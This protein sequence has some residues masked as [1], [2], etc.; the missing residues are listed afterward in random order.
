MVE[1]VGR[2]MAM[3]VAFLVVSIGLLV[4]PD[5]PFRLGLDL[6]GGTRLVY[7]FDFEQARADG[8]L[9][10]E[11]TD[12]EVL[13][14]QIGIINNRVDPDGVLNPVI[15]SE[16]TNRIVIELP[17]KVNEERATAPL[18]AALTQT[19]S[20][21]LI[22]QG[23]SEA[24][25]FPLDG[26]V[27]LVGG[28][29]I[30]YAQRRGTELRGLTRGMGGGAQAGQHTQGTDVQLISGDP[31]RTRIENLGQLKFRILADANS[32]QRNVTDEVAER[33]KLDAW[34]TANPDATNL[35]GFN[36]LAGTAEGPIGVEWYPHKQVDGAAEM[37]LSERA[38][39][40]IVQSNEDWEFGGEDLGAVWLIP[41]DERTTFPACGFRMTS[42]ARNDF[43]DFT[44]ANS[45]KQLGIILNNEI[46]TAPGLDEPLTGDSRITGRFQLEEVKDLITVLRT[47]SLRIRPTLEHEESVGPTLGE[48]YVK[49]GMLSGAIGL[50]AVLGF[51]IAYYKRLGAFAAISLVANMVMLMGAMAFLRSTLTL[52]GIAGLILTVGMAV[53]ANILIFDRVR[54]EAEKNSKINPKQAAKNGFQH[55]TSAILDANITTLLTALILYNVGTGPVRGFAVTLSVGVITSVFSALAITRMLMHWDFLR[56]EKAKTKPEHY[57]MGAWL[58]KADYGFVGRARTMWM[59]SAVVI[60]IGLVRFISLPDSSKL[61]IDFLGGQTMRI[62]VEEPQS[63]DDVIGALESAGVRPGGS[64][65][66]VRPV[67][68]SADGDG[69]RSFR[70]VAK[71]SDSGGDEAQAEFELLLQDGD[72]GAPAPTGADA[73]QAPAEQAPLEQAAQDLEEAAGS[74]AEAAPEVPLIESPAPAPTPS[75]AAAPAEDD[76][77]L[78]TFRGDVQAALSELLQK[79]P[80]E[81]VSLEEVDGQRRTELRLYF[82][83]TH[84]PEDIAARLRT[85]NMIEANVSGTEAPGVYTASGTVNFGMDRGSFQVRLRR[86]F[87]GE[88]DSNEAAYVLREPISEAR[89]V[90]EQVVGEL[91][92]KA[93]L[94]ILI[95][96]FAI[97]MYIRVRFAEYSYGIA[98]VVA[99]SHDVL[100][101]LG[102][103]SFV[104]WLIP[105]MGVEINLPMI[106]AFLTIIGYSL[107][108]TIVVFDRVR[109]NLPRHERP[110]REI[111]DLSI[112]QTLSRT[113]MTSMT[114]LIAVLLLFVFNFGSANTLVGFSMAM[115][116]GVLVGTYSSMFI[117]CPVF[118]ALEEKRRAKEA[119]ENA[120]EGE[121]VASAKGSEQQALA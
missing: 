33:Q 91:R 66:E 8:V 44:G 64:P 79:G 115:I 96:L 86:A 5:E 103:M 57:Q 61:G 81:V 116:L 99:L 28:E 6:S 87:E 105:S 68:D 2:Y 112:N 53:D 36:A 117:A 63:A 104:M 43:G 12:A 48:A 114:T 77:E 16:G 42:E 32:Y 34:L 73:E 92:D 93:I 4:V 10:T 31:I 3:I 107:N 17:G 14:D 19:D 106:A 60:L 45:G 56:H 118:C 67:I 70:L 40:V 113:I 62:N 24:G 25:A 29:K 59:I 98:V 71:E 65:V 75:A 22:G 90:G 15:R 50:L 1:N 111:V 38:Q 119:A 83:G 18:G 74:A 55:A 35:E 41:F 26:G 88:Q 101:T 30:R 94:A 108:D 80:I 110:L 97:V 95:S 72:E 51:M 85:A 46:Y 121:T 120:E 84:A 20:V 47:G 76:S 78:E 39:A 7:S 89:T 100:V 69:Y 37:P 52:P 58:A 27:V 102:V 21:L 82:E 54:E 109:E 11:E 23:G 13:Q 9:Q 49:R